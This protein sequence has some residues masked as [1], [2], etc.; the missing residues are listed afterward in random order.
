MVALVRIVLRDY[1]GSFLPATVVAEFE[2]NSVNP[3]PDMNEEEEKNPEFYKPITCRRAV[4]RYSQLKALNKLSQ[5][6]NENI[7]KGY[8]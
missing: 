4:S 5:T 2:L 1:P 6:L 7:K 3:P 8:I